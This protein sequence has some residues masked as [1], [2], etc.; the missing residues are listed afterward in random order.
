MRKKIEEF[1][2]TVFIVIGIM[3]IVFGIGFAVTGTT[4]QAEEQSMEE[5]IQI[6][7]STMMEIKKLFLEQQQQLQEEQ[8][9]G[10][11]WYT[12]YQKIKGCVSASQDHYQAL[13]C[14]GIKTALN[15]SK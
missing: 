11:H 6:H 10:L 4:A 8:E 15:E 3:L 1:L 5:T 2:N 14:A 7:K 13:T 12:Q 9:I